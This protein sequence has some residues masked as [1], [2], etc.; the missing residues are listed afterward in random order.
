MDA[1]LKRRL[2]EKMF[3]DMESAMGPSG[4]PFNVI[5]DVQTGGRFVSQQPIALQSIG[6]RLAYF[7]P[8]LQSLNNYLRTSPNCI[9]RNIHGSMQIMIA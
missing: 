5:A 4:T 1:G 2:A 7:W 8:H 3:S 6:D 9:C